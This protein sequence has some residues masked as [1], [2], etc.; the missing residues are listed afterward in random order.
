MK[1]SKSTLVLLAIIGLA[2]L[3]AA[4]AAAD[5][6]NE[7]WQDATDVYDGNNEE[8]TV[9]AAGGGNP[10][11]EDWF[12]IALTDG[13]FLKLGLLIT[14]PTQGWIGLRVYGPDDHTRLAAYDTRNDV[15]ALE[16]DMF[17]FVNGTYYIRVY[18]NDG[19]Q[20]PY[21]MEVHVQ[22]PMTL[23][24]GTQ[25]SIGGTDSLRGRIIS[26]MWFSVWLKGGNNT[27]EMADVTLNW[28]GTSDTDAHITIFDRQNNFALNPLNYSWSRN[29][30]HNEACRFAASY[31]GLYY[32]RIHTTTLF[33][34]VI[35]AVAFDV[36]ATVLGSQ[37]RADGNVQRSDAEF[38]KI[39]KAVNGKL[40]E[41]YDTHDWYTFYLNKGEQF[42]AKATFS[43]S[44]LTTHWDYYRL[45]LFA[46][47]GTMIVTALNTGAGG[48]GDPPISV[49]SIF[50]GKAEYT[51][52]YYLSISAAWS[53]SGSGTTDYTGGKLVNTA[54]YEID[55]LI[56]N[57]RVW[58]V[59]PP[60]EIRM[61]EDSEYTIDLTMVF[62]DPETDDL[63]FGTLGGKTNFTLIL[64]QS[65]GLLT[66]RPNPNWY[67]SEEISIWAHDGRP[68]QRNVTKVTLV[69]KS[70]ADPP[71]VKDG[72]PLTVTIDEDEINTT[73]LILY[74]VFGD[75]DIEDRFL[76]F[77]S[78]QNEFVSLEIDQA[79]G[80]ITLWG[81]KDYHGSQRLTFYAADTYNYR[82]S[83][84]ITV[85]VTPTND[86]PVAVGKI[87]RITMTAGS[88]S[89]IDVGTFFEDIDE[90]ELYYYAQW[91]QE[92]AIAFD[93]IDSNPTNSWFDIY[94]EDPNFYGFVQVIFVCYDRDPLDP[95][96]FPEEARQSAILEVENENDA[97][98]IDVWEPDYDP[99]IN[100]LESVTFKV[101]EDLIYD[102]DS[103]MF[104]WKWFVNDLE[105]VDVSGDTFEFPKDP[106][107]D[108]AGTYLIR[109]EVKDS[110]GA[111][112][113]I[114]PEWIL[115]IK[116][117]NRP[118]TINLVSKD[119]TLEEG[120][121]I[122][123]RADGY[124]QDDD[125]LIFEWYQMDDAGRE[126]KVGLGRDFQLDKPLSPGS[127]RFKCIVSD[128]EAQVSSNFV[129]VDVGAH[130]F[131]PTIPGFGAVFAIAA[132][133]A[134][135]LLMAISRRRY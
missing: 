114:D 123:L 116:N 90:D 111:E 15:N 41:A 31:T 13:T 14:D 69:V 51:G 33:S 86:A 11:D 74:T 101:P 30:D 81:A 65:T 75:V 80:R 107:Y 19:D 76:I 54:K 122:R 57:R 127:Y 131:P 38:I 130:D 6:G 84:T 110:L 96:M 16:I 8:H 32:I 44:L 100:E 12:R 72:A 126:H 79:S 99:T 125:S 120:E 52:K 78:D 20:A 7:N 92:D 55:V 66:I 39:R 42:R 5:P 104:R 118:P 117:T 9:Q 34:D 21:R 49:M 24:S 43:N 113:N 103:S 83:H 10:A 91:D 89:H 27:V 61:F 40:V 53:W 88:N 68:D 2:V 73:A 26:S 119:I 134:S 94:P 121:D 64:A 128:G 102:V 56:P 108:D 135:V 1:P 132:L 85:I 106:T 23:S 105:Q 93:N 82:V 29:Q 98:R 70:V 48:L 133:S 25:V 3:F 59:D 50:V 47:N 109:C 71:T 112:A 95:D 4:S 60:G 46:S 124:D 77:S 58:I 36:K 18:I 37:Y 115:T 45:T 63:T 67:G 35:Y 129:Q 28:P 17:V 97:P 87:P 62:W 22:R